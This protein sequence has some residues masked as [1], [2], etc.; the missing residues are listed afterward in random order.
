MKIQSTKANSSDDCKWSSLSSGAEV[1]EEQSASD[2]EAAR[3]TNNTL[4]I[5]LRSRDLL[6]VNDISFSVE[7]YCSA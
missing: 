2:H 6:H 4:G 5:C 7:L 3:E 1:S